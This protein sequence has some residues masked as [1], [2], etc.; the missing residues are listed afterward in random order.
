MNLFFRA[1]CQ[2][3]IFMICAQ[4]IVH[5]RPNGSYE[6]YLKMLVSVMILVQVFLPIARLFSGG[7]Q[8]GIENTITQF[9]SRLEESMNQAAKAAAES[10]QLLGNM[11]LEEVR[12]RME[13]EQQEAQQEQ[14]DENGE[15]Q[16]DTVGQMQNDGEVGGG[17]REDGGEK[18]GQDVSPVGIDRIKVEIGKAEG[19]GNSQ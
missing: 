5:F 8:Q 11:S 1:I 18:A 14:P 6:K 9:E 17:N 3:G 7:T 16:G 13:S 4:A 15:D 2:L 10:D 12:K 19:A